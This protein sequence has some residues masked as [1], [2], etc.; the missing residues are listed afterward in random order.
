MQKIVRICVKFFI[1]LFIFQKLTKVARDDSHEGKRR[2][3][4]FA[5]IGVV[6]WLCSATYN[7]AI[8]PNKWGNFAVP[9]R[10]SV[11]AFVMPRRTKRPADTMVPCSQEV[12]HFEWNM[13][14]GAI[15]P[16]PHL[17]YDRTPPTHFMLQTSNLVRLL[18]SHGRL[19]VVQI[20][21]KP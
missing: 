6:K 1:Y 17:A 18:F 19:K 7:I 11:H 5:N 3:W 21:L 9:L 4:V 10:N 15:F 16:F 13:R 8:T 12:G 14:F 20:F 2:N